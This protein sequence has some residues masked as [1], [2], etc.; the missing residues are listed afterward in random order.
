ME[1]WKLRLRR[2]PA[3]DIWVVGTNPDRSPDRLNRGHPAEK[4]TVG[5]VGFFDR[6]EVQRLIEASSVD[7]ECANANTVEPCLSETE[8]DL[9][10]SPRS[11]C[12]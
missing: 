4:E 9:C 12:R 7:F 3:S 6:F 1:A 8:R 10:C 11:R 2:E 5:G